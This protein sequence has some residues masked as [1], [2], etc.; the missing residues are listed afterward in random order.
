VMDSLASSSSGFVSLTKTAGRLNFSCSTIVRC[1]LSVAIVATMARKRSPKAPS[2]KQAA[3]R[4]TWKK[5]KDMVVSTLAR[6][7]RPIDLVSKS[8]RAHLL[9]SFTAQTPVERLQLLFHARA[10]AH[11]RRADLCAKEGPRYHGQCRRYN[12]LCATRGCSGS[13]VAQ[14]Q[15]HGLNSLQEVL[16]M[17]ALDKARYNQEMHKWLATRGGSTAE[18]ERDRVATTDGLVHVTDEESLGDNESHTTLDV[19]VTTSEDFLGGITPFAES[20]L[21]HEFVHSSFG[22]SDFT[23][24]I[25]LEDAETSFSQIATGSFGDPSFLPS[26]ISIGRLSTEDNEYKSSTWKSHC[27][28][29]KPELTDSDGGGGRDLD[30]EPLDLVTTA[31]ALQNWP[32]VSR[33]LTL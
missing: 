20:G 31:S 12:G 24:G 30:Y 29:G 21:P 1:I 9:V 15:G 7:T 4:W 19:P 25:A 32:D 22:R 26:E 2:P 23:E 33:L 6:G 27:H 11:A 18:P 8:K 28:F 16:D 10:K 17:A 5:D 3:K 14:G 13:R